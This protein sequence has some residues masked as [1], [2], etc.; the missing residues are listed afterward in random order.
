M[1]PTKYSFASEQQIFPKN[2][3]GPAG[4]G[5]DHLFMGDE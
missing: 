1:H 4:E 5:V 2:I 3:P